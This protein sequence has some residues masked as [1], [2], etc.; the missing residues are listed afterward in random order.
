DRNAKLSDAD[1]KAQGMAGVRVFDVEVELQESDTQ[2]LRDGF[3]ATVEFP[4]E[5]LQGVVSVPISAVIR[6]EGGE[7]VQVLTDTGVELR[8][9]ETGPTGRRAGAPHLPGQRVNEIVVK[10]GLSAGDRVLP[11]SETPEPATQTDTAAQHAAP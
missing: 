6:K 9:I 11:G 7:Y 2:R 4:G 5:M 10:S 8:K 1:V 3:Q